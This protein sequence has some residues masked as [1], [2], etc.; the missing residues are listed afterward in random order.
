MPED[1]DSLETVAI[2][3]LASGRRSQ[4]TVTHRRDAE[5]SAELFACRARWRQ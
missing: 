3:R 1:Q 4:G 2:H 5:S